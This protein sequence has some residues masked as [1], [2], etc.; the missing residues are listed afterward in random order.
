MRRRLLKLGAAAGWLAGLGGSVPIGAGAGGVTPASGA[1]AAAAGAGTAAVAASAAP[2]T[3][4]QDFDTLWTRFLVRFVQ[5]DGRVIDPDTPAQ[6]S[7][8]EG[9]AYTLFFALVADDRARF[10]RVL[11]WTRR[12]LAGGDFAARLPAWQ[13]G[14]RPD[15][16]WG[17]LDSHAASDADLWLA[18]ALFEADRAWG[19]PA[20]AEQARAVLKLVVR[21]EVADV[22]GL[23]PMLL[24]GPVGFV[25]DDRRTWRFNP[26]YF[27]LHQLRALAVFDPAGP[28]AALV[29]TGAAMLQ[30][31]CPEGL[32]PDWVAWQLDPAV[33]A[34]PV[35]S[36]PP[37]PPQGRWVAD[38]AQADVGS[39]DA[40][41]CYLW[42]GVASAQD[43]VR[44]ALLNS[45]RGLRTRVRAGA[46][47]PERL[48]TRSAAD[49]GSGL[50]PP[51]FDAAA[52]PYLSALGARDAVVDRLTRLQSAV[53]SRPLRY[54][55]HALLLFG[56]GWLQERWRC[57]R[58]GRLLR[59]LPSRPSG[60]SP[61]PSLTCRTPT[62]T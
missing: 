43:E 21:D 6:V 56:I 35:A 44:P 4:C 45:L 24:P 52:L 61:D 62:P 3:S 31:A 57:D 11:D 60:A 54:Y 32:A 46:A 29:R 58:D 12:E 34:G 5:A 28:W 22:P 15:G 50:A 23:G 17:V 42:A 30:A 47:L 39:Y 1:A 33:P 8:S 16:S 10:D 49:V 27:V 14:R 48:R 40:I 19:V 18:L 20:Y 13:W 7:T 2:D 53:R 9:Q 55:D 51:A 59:Q 26:S 37:S 25:S 41:R 38:P 36:A